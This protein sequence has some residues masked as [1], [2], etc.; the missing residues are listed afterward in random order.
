MADVRVNKKTGKVMVDHVYV[1]LTAGLS[2]NPG[3][4]ENQLVGGVTQILSRLLFEQL[5]FGKGRTASF[6]FVSY[7][8]MRFKDAPK[9]TAIVVQQPYETLS[10]IGEPV[11]LVAS[12]AVANA[13]FDAT[14]VRMRTAPYTPPRVRA[15]LVAA[16]A[17]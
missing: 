15:A 17:A 3:F 9:V 16:G 14:G 2:V 13:F 7:P 6:D 4:V 1:A 8:I 11:T 10:G 12:A 5:R